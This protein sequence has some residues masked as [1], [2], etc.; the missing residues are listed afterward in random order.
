MSRS[1]FCFNETS[2]SAAGTAA[3]SKYVQNAASYL[4]PGVAGPLGDFSAVDVEVD[5][6]GAV[7]GTLSVFVQVSPDDGVSWYDIISFP[8]LAAGAAAVSYRS[9]ISNATGTSTPTKVGKNLAPALASSTVV[10][11][12]F[13]DRMRLVFVA[14]SGTT[15]GAQVVARL[16]AQRGERN[17]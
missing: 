1:N 4:P 5:L 15:A 17:R 11:G 12:A 10:N 7:G 9:P 3:S 16:V 2:P 14:G 13:T 6:V 8:T